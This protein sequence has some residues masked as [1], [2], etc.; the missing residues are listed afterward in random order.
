M[1]W[2]CLDTSN[3]LAGRFW[4]VLTKLLCGAKVANGEVGGGSTFRAGQSTPG[5]VVR[6]A[7]LEVD[8]KL[9][10]VFANDDLLFL[11]SENLCFNL[12]NG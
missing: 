6:T 7:K 3:F 11:P 4:L 2:N 8:E 9:V 10:F 5:T 1:S 12:G